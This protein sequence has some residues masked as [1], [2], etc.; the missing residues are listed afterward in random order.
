[1]P[2]FSANLTFL[3]TE[4]PFLERFAAAAA[5][6]FPAVEYVGPYDHPPEVIADLLKQHNLKQALFN[7]PA[8]DWAGGERGIGC[9]PD[10]VEEFQAGVATAIRYGKALGCS[11]I[12]CLAGIAPAGVDRDVLQS[13]LVENLKYAAPRLAEAGIKLL[14]EPINQRDMPGFF[15]STTDHAE[16]IMADVNSSNLFLQ[17]DIYHTQVMQGDLLS[18]YERLSNRIAHIQIADNPGRN[19]PGTGEINYAN[20][21]PALDRL[22]YDGFVGCEYKPKTTTTA[23]LGWMQPYR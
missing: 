22:G 21:L 13:T 5:D 10:R 20:I 19:E 1:M 7:L 11:K 15:V 9:F 6:G 8:G 17:Y 16:A 2:E 3:Y 14:M 4:L 12:N 18:T 23:G